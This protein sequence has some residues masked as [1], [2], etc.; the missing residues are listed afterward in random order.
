MGSPSDMMLANLITFQVKEALNWPLA[1]AIAS[2]LMCAVSLL[3]WV[4]FRFAESTSPG[5]SA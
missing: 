5:I 1:A 3:A 4:Y 2:T